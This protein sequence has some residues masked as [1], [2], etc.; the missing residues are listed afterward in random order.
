[1]FKSSIPLSVQFELTYR[2]NNRCIFC[3]N[4]ETNRKLRPVDTAQAK[5]ILE[6]LASSGVLSV[7]FNGGEPLTRSDFFELASYAKS[8]GLDIHLNSNVTLVR[9]QETAE[10]IAVFFPAICTSLL[11]ADPALHDHLSGREGAFD[12]VIQG[13]KLLQQAGVYVAVNIMLSRKNASGLRQTLELLRHL[14]IKTVLITRYVACECGQSGL[15]IEDASFFEQLR[16]VATYQQEHQCFARIALPQPVQLCRVPGDMRKIIQK[17]NIP[18]NIGLCTA[19]VGCTG[20]L[21]PCNLVKEP[22]L[23]NLLTE[24][25]KNLWNRFDGC[26]FFAGKH[27]LKDC[28]DC[29]YL[30]ECGGGCMGYNNGLCNTEKR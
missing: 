7:N 25:L 29:G 21:S 16:M 1:M 22:C 15:H 28:S 17:W 20:K 14:G 3:Y 8:L 30:L 12:E 18:C 10:K 24:S 11:S 2:C 13:I 23:G 27:L 9:N 6:D 19:S 26:S 4:G 5:R